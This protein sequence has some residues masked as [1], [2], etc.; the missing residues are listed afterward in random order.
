[1]DGWVSRVPWVVVTLGI[2]A[3]FVLGLFLWYDWAGL[4]AMTYVGWAIWVPSLVLGW[5]PILVLRRRAG[6]Q[7]G[8][9]Y[10]HTTVLVDSGLYRVV[11]HPQY[12]SFM[13][14][15]LAL[16][17]VS[18]HWIVVLIGVAVIVSVYL[19]MRDEDKRLVDKFGDD[20]VRYMRAVPRANFVVG[21]VR[22]ARRGPRRDS[23]EGGASNGL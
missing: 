10:V 4:D 14:L 15:S 20:Y 3:Q 17:L 19:V 2:A 18:Q 23:A 8:E 16:M 12:L 5:L 7:K 9:T 21:L 6:V 13:L 22:L 1:M 11:R